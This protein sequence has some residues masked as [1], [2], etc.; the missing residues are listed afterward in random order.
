MTETAGKGNKGVVT[1]LFNF[2]VTAVLLLLVVRYMIN[3]LVMANWYFW[4]LVIGIQRA[5]QGLL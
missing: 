5:A 1:S 4:F 3:T 2:Q